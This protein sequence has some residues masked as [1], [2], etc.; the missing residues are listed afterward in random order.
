MEFTFKVEVSTGH[1]WVAYK[2]FIESLRHEL[3]S[4]RSSH[5]RPVLHDPNEIDDPNETNRRFCVVVLQTIQNTE[6]HEIK[7]RIRRDNLYLD[8]YQ[9]ENSDQWLQFGSG[10]PESNFLGF[11]GSYNDLQ[12]AARQSIDR[13]NLGQPQLITAVNQLAWTEDRQERAK[14]LI[15]VIQM[16]CESIRFSR[17]SEHLATQ[18][19]PGSPPPTWMTALEHGWGTLSEA[20]LRADADATHYFRLPQPNDMQITIA[21]EAAAALGIL[22]FFNF[23]KPRPPRTL[24]AAEDNNMCLP[25]G[26][27][28]VEVF[29]VRI[30]NID[31][32]NP[33]ELYGTITVADG[34]GSYDSFTVKL[35]LLDRDAV[36][37]DDEVSNGEIAWNVFDT[38]NVFD[39]ILYADVK[40]E[41][42]SA[43]VCYTV[44]SDAVEAT[45]A[46]RL[47]NGDGENPADVY[48]DISASYSDY[49]SGE[50]TLLFRKKKEEY[51]NVSP[52][53]C[54]VL[55]KKTVAVP[56]KNSLSVRAELY[57]HDTITPDDEIANGTADFPPLFHGTSEKNIAGK[58]GEIRVVV[59]WNKSWGNEL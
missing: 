14:Q 35:H 55:T 12:N 32:E 31:G 53:E 51:I 41:N 40:G 18:Y 16:I 20:L 3:A 42:G 48:G 5:G 4:S 47:I 11:G 9:M 22:L 33:G 54:I 21:E 13:I 43:R 37:W 17:I 39:S 28:M 27:R 24:L 36:S 23:G 50:K 45:I 25:Q 26:R 56:T 46:V 57:D 10:H 49:P 2:K 58:Y 8:G 6:Q 38:A 59:T 19:N 1:E 52:G 15:V 7:L 44:L 34:L 29:W 30:D